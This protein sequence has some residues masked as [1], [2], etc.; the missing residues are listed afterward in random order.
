MELWTDV[1]ELP[2]FQNKLEDVKL[3]KLG[4]EGG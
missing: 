1:S 2:L 3:G 4:W